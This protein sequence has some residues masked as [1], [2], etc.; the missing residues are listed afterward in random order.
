MNKYYCY[1]HHELEEV[2]KDK[3]CVWEREV[4][5]YHPGAVMCFDPDCPC[6]AHSRESL[7]F[8]ENLLKEKQKGGS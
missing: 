4:A 5:L 7:A 6:K 8:K 3:T 1:Y 2:S